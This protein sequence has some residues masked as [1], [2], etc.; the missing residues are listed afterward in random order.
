MDANRVV[1]SSVEGKGGTVGPESYATAIKS[2]VGCKKYV[3]SETMAVV[4]NECE[5]PLKTTT[6]SGAS[7]CQP[8]FCL[9]NKLL[10]S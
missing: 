8:P 2:L 5:T 4:V 9:L 3:L 6:I 1:N 10:E 7:L